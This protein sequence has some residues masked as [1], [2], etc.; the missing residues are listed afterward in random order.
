[1]HFLEFLFWEIIIEDKI[2]ILNE[3]ARSLYMY[4]NHLLIYK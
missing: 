1:M 4:I 2:D 3:Y